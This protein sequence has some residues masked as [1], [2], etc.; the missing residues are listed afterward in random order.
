MENSGQ[1][2]R[3]I[4]AKRKRRQEITFSYL[5]LLPYLLLLV[6]FGLFPIAYAF[7]LSF[8]DSIDM[9]F[10]GLE[11]Y[12]FVFSDFRLSQ[13]AINVILFLC[14]WLS[15]T[16]VFVTLLSLILDGLRPKVANGIRTLFFLPGAVTSS[17]TVVLWLFVLDPTVS[18]FLPIYELIGW[19][20]RQMVINGLGF[21][22]IFAIMA[23]FAHSGGWIVVTG[24]ALSSLSREVL[25]AG[26]V[27]G[28]SGLQQAFWIKLP[29]IWRTVVLMGILTAA[30]ALQLFNEP[31]LITMAGPQFTQ[32]DW[33]PN[34][35]SFGYAFSMGDFGAAA[36]L[37][38]ILVAIS[39]TIAL[40]VIY[41]TDF[42]RTE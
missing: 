42:Y 1:K 16:V 10:Y 30:G 2:T 32:T 40:I 33:A 28:A 26:R 3:A 34:Q 29:M 6:M 5:M 19:D 14:L 12:R 11:N 37:N 25:E 15:A 20:T 17:A 38:T 23:Y 8:F 7:G 13:S 4:Q 35:L 31:H 27:D 39:I 21:A 36:A 9:V 24:G 18:P 22:G 41:A